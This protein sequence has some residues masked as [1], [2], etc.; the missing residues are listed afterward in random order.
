MRRGVVE[1]KTLSTGQTISLTAHEDKTLRH[2]Y[3]YMA[4]YSKRLTLTN[5]IDK[6]KEEYKQFA[7]PASNCS[8]PT[9]KPIFIDTVSSSPNAK[10]CPFFL[11]CHLF[12]VTVAAFIVTLLF[13]FLL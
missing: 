11:Q 6:K 4:G 13:S 1:P 8:S 12:T 7:A 5:M 9:K 3:D 10:V 2:A